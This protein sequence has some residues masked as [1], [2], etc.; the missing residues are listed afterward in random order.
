MSAVVSFLRNTAAVLAGLVVGMAV[1]IALIELNTKLL[2]PIPPGLQ[3]RHM[4]EFSRYIA[5]L[6]LPAFILVF[7]AHFGQAAVG[8]YVA[9][10]LGTAKPMV[11]TQIV[12]TLTLIGSIINNLSIP[13]P[14]WTWIE[15]PCYPVISWMV[16]RA[17]QKSQNEAK[18]KGN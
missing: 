16:G 14:A 3:F 18:A 10:R 8:G 9:A 5:R 1:N 17:V 13:V 6:P 15:M 12:G 11:L 4:E 2:Y 7:A